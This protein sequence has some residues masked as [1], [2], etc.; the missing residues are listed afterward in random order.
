MQLNKPPVIKAYW[1]CDQ[2]PNY[3]FDRID[4]SLLFS[5]LI[6]QDMS[7]LTFRKM[8]EVSPHPEDELFGKSEQLND[9]DYDDM[10]DSC[11]D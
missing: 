1:V 10:E 5:D 7:E 11:D 9:D 6:F 3:K 2:I 4:V 8:F